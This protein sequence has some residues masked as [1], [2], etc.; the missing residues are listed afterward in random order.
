MTKMVPSE[1]AAVNPKAYPL[2]DSQLAQ[3]IQELVSQAAN[4]K[5]LK[6]GANEATKTLNRG[7]AEFVV[8]AADAEP[9]EILLHLPLL[10]EDKNVPY[11]FVPSKQALGRACGVTRPVIAC[12]V[13]SNEGSSLR[14]PINNLK[15]AIEKLLI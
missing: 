14:D 4:Y 11:V 15:V 3:A 8:M 12:S 10:T 5:Q 9:L 2:A 6:K 1:E 7:I 13:T